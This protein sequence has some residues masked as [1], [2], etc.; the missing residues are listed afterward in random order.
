MKKLHLLCNAHLDPVW[1]WR[2]NE[3]IATA[4]STFRVAADFC[5]EYNGF[6]FN[7]NEALLYE[8]VEQYEPALFER[9]KKLVACGKW[10]I[11]GGWYLQPDCVMT[12]GESLKSQIDLGREYFM[13]KF[14]VE[15]T[16]AINFDPFGHSRGLVQLMVKKGYDSYIFM[17]PDSLK[18]DFLWEGFDG[19]QV[20]AHG[21]Y[22]I[23]CTHLGE[24]VNKLK[25]YMKD[26]PDKEIGLCLWG[27]G[28]HGGGPSRRE[29]DEIHEFAKDCDTPIVHSSA[30]E[31][32]AEID[33]SNLGV[34]AKSLGPSMV[35]CYTSQVRVKQANRRV[36]NKIAM[37]EKALCY[38]GIDA[39]KEMKEAKKTLAYCQFHD[40][41]P[42][43]AIKPVEEDSLRTFG[44]AEEIAEKLYDKA[45]FELC[46]GQKKCKSGEI[47]VMIFNPHPYEIESEFQVEFILEDQNWNLGEYT[48]AQVYDEA[49]NFLPT[50]NE[51]PC[52]PFDLDWV[53]KISFR[54]CIAPSSIT[55][56]DCKL[57]TL[58][59][60]D[61]PKKEYDEDFVT[62]ENDRM[63]AR[64]SR[65]TGLIDLYR[66]DGKTYI[67]NSGK[68][69]VYRDNEDPWGFFDEAYNDYECDF[70]LMSDKDANAFNGQPDC[71]FKN[72]RV[73]EDGDV[74]TKIQATFEYKRNVAVVEYTI[75]KKDAYIDVDI[76]ML[77][78]EPQKMIKYHIDSKISGT[79]YGETA[80]G[81]EELDKCEKESVFH[82]WCGLKNDSDALYV[83]NRGTYGGSFTESSIKMSLLRTPVYSALPLEDLRTGDMEE[84]RPIVP[85]GR[86]LDHIDMGER[87]YSFRITTEEN[88]SKEAQIFNE[89]PHVISFFPSG[90]GKKRESFV[91]LDN[92]NVIL[93]SLKKKGDGY[94]VTLYNA[95][96]VPQEA[97]LEIAGK[98]EE[99]K[100]G[101]YELKIMMI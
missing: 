25:D 66:V 57:T 29:L 58:K 56:F 96:N 1:L 30:E 50:Q 87:N 62:V 45:F 28:N 43:S 67:E 83:I 38:A 76:K 90:D 7:H 48:Y 34:V 75:P 52:C 61:I 94:E 3:G 81:Y 55:R 22:G 8:W 68:L 71:D 88:I 86:M 69:E 92:A 60:A 85:K 39:E 80:F 72:V 41:L 32:M 74:R 24:T 33:R 77:S 70:A 9:I 54:A 17:R 35:G 84:S 49:G 63:T 11:M 18:S 79:P 73:V 40:I 42:G 95:T 51:Q 19:S 65:K 26:Y 6:V 27:L 31:Y 13:E 21:C 36:E 100:F 10:K 59:M 5:D 98:K 37:A 2:R 89:A 64:I 4:L 12:S 23:Y 47:P 93:S 16:T 101:K 99:L 97:V 91:K 46:Q 44:Y 15:P 53:K 14:G 82:K 78:S 20:L